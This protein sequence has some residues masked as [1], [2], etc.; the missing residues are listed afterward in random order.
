MKEKGNVANIKRFVDEFGGQTLFMPK[1]NPKPEDYMITFNGNVEDNYKIGMAVTKKSVKLYTGFY[2]SDI[3]IASPLGLRMIIGAE[4]EKDRD[5][6]FLSSIEMLIMD[7][8]DVFIMQNWDHVLHIVR[9]LHLQPVTTHGTDFARI[10]PWALDGMSKYYCQSLIFCS[11]ACPEHSSL[12]SKYFKNYTGQVRVLPNSLK[13]T[14][15]HVTVQLPQVFQSFDCGSVHEVDEARFDYFTKHVLPN[16]KG[17]LMSHTLIF[18]SSYFDFVRIR[19]YFKREEASFVQICEYT[20]DKKIA[21]SRDYFFHGKSQ[22]LLYTER[23]QFFRRFQLKGVGHI[24]FYQLPQNP[25]FYPELCNLIQENFQNKRVRQ[26]KN[27]SVNVIYCK[28]DVPRLSAIVGTERA[29]HMISSEKKI[30]AFV[31]GEM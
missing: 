30:H 11:V 23:A 13:G 10:R 22:F 18:V 17:R 21:R 27:S 3:I 7:Q 2:S 5:Y 16:F 28:Y 6:D 31:S 15:C 1:T 25:Q 9:H 20:K 26:R 4:G 24:I 14:I 12:M 19:N 8:A 29:G